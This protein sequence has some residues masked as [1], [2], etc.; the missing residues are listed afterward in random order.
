M[1]AIDPANKE[2]LHVI[3]SSAFIICLD[4]GAPTTST[5]RAYHFHFGDGS[6]RWNDKCSQFVVCSNGVSGFVGDHSMLDAGTVNGLNA[7]IMHAILEYKPETALN[8]QNGHSNLPTLQEYVFKY[9]PALEK[10]IVRT[11]QQF[12]TNIS[13]WEHVFLTYS[14]YGG[15]FL[16]ARK[17][18]P[19]SAFQIIV[20]LAG[21]KY[22]GY[23]IY[24]WETVSVAT[25]NKGRVELNQILWPEVVE[26]CN[27]AYDASTNTKQQRSKEE[28]RKLF[29]DACRAHSNSVIRASRGHG[30]VRHMDGLLSMLQESEPMPAL[31]EDPVLGKTRVYDF[32]SHC[33]ESDML[34]KGFVLALP[35]EEPRH[36]WVHYEVYDEE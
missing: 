23:Q 4:D 32:M 20:Q 3:E 34:E 35:G 27:A 29:Y 9:T 26:F 8:G 12:N 21:R 30:T 36:I 25:F 7:A 18:P 24:C 5:E 16:R 10:E 17:C 13:G 28:L 2:Y 19:K 11:R 6:N 33:H 1:K 22:F 31:F 15:T 14:S